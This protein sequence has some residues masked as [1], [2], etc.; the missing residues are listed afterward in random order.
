[1]G[2]SRP[3]RH[4]DGDGS[5]Y[6]ECREIVVGSRAAMALCLGRRGVFEL[7]VHFLSAGDHFRSRYSA[8]EC[9]GALV[10]SPT[11]GS[12]RT[13]QPDA[14]SAA[15]APP[16]CSGHHSETI[17]TPRSTITADDELPNDSK[18]VLGR[19]QWHGHQGG[20]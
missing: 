4:N 13:R 10:R 3:G 7:A 5:E 9:R 2:L 6:R 16:V 1:M 19:T 17:D 8:A 11:D 14:T 12:N 15:E 20:S 18:L